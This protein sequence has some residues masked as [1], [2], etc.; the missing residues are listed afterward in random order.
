MQREIRKLIE[1]FQVEGRFS[2]AH[3]I[4]SGHIHDSWRVTC[5]KT[6]LKYRYVLQRINHDIFHKPEEVMENI[7]RVSRHLRARLES[8]GFSDLER[9]YL[10]VVPTLEGETFYRDEEQQYWRVYEFIENARSYDT[11]QSRD[12]A[13]EAA[14]AF[15]NFLAQMDS[16][17]G[18]ALHETIPGFLSGVPRYAALLEA[19]KDDA[20]GRC[21]SARGEIAFALE[22]ESIVLIPP[23]L[24]AECVI[25]RRVT[26]NDCKINNVMM[27]HDTG[28]ALCVIDLDTVMPG[29]VIYDFGDLV[30]TAA[31]PAA[32]DEKDLTRMELELPLFQALLEGYRDGAGA[33]LSQA[34]VNQLGFAGKYMAYLHV[35]RFLTDYLRGD[36]YYKTDYPQQNLDR[37]RTQIALVRSM[38]TQRDNI[39]AIVRNYTP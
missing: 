16:M 3:P 20:V 17:P 1:R 5:R 6:Q 36:I 33:A 25:F 31:C 14:R 24:E 34:E 30:R 11:V 13:Y 7:T 26:H 4:E 28:E 18:P 27:D 35:L 2:Q 37:C 10:Q 9:R 32:E 12:H 29:L 15:G 23:R 22:R 38:E 19:L 8:E 21:D 39:A